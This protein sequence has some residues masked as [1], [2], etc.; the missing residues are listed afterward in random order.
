MAPTTNRHDAP[1]LAKQLAWQ[2][3]IVESCPDAIIGIDLQGLI[4]S[5]NRAAARVLGYGFAEIVG[6]QWGRLLGGRAGGD[7]GARMAALLRGDPGGAIHL[8][9]RTGGPVEP[10]AMLSPIRDGAQAIIGASIIVRATGAPGHTAGNVRA[11]GSLDPRAVENG[12]DHPRGQKAC[13]GTASPMQRSEEF[14]ST[15]S[16]E[17]R[18][19]LHAMLGW[20]EVLQQ[21]AEPSMRHGL[22]I[23]ERNGRLQ[24]QLLEDLLD[25]GRANAGK[26]RLEIATVDLGSILSERVD[27]MRPAAEA[28]RLELTLRR[29]A[30]QCEVLGDA[31]R[32][33]Q[34]L[35]NLLSN[36]IQY[37]APGGRVE[38]TLRGEPD[39]FR[40]DVTDSGV[41]IEADFIPHVFT[42]YAQARQPRNGEHRGLGLGLAIVQQLVALHG[43]TVAAAS[44]GRGHGSTFT[45]ILPRVPEAPRRSL[46]RRPSAPATL[47]ART[48]GVH[49]QVRSRLRPG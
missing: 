3:A 9:D 41:G 8:I 26:L 10:A 7:P 5:W 30:Y 24:A 2:A 15:L 34:I 35:W 21:S 18:A 25:V 20:A 32:L 16:H 22:A 12:E 31:T 38:V 49:G 43:G 17:L 36:A 23:I 19:P 13:V 14:L 37:T 1:T 4:V 33:Q 42:R 28:K 46:D 40:I 6:Q 27:S 11:P 44:D 47:A 45:L 39:G 48:T 29:P